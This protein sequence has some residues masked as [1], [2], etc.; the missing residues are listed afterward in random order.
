MLPNILNLINQTTS[1][2]ELFSVYSIDFQNG[3]CYNLKCVPIKRFEKYLNFPKV[4]ET[5][6]C[7]S[8]VTF[9]LE[10]CKDCVQYNFCKLQ[11]HNKKARTPKFMC[12]TICHATLHV[13]LFVRPT[14]QAF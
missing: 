12:A 4:F 3:F 11:S 7:Q 13:R 6:R 14:Y 5:K 2:N 1:Q 9:A 8:C 10:I